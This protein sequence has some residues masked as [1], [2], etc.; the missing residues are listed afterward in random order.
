MTIN[1]IHWKRSSCKGTLHLQYLF[2]STNICSWLTK[3]IPTYLLDPIYDILMHIPSWSRNVH[4]FTYYPP[5]FTVWKPVKQRTIKQPIMVTIAVSK[6]QH[7]CNKKY[8]VLVVWS[9]SELVKV[10]W[11]SGQ[12]VLPSTPTICYDSC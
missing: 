5:T 2:C 9:N 8:F 4:V 3:I 1:R 10:W 11:F 12:G 6:F 7:A